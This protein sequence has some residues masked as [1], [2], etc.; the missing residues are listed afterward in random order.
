MKMNLQKLVRKKHNKLYFAGGTP[1]EKKLLTLIHKANTFEIKLMHATLKKDGV[2]YDTLWNEQVEWRQ[3]AHD[4]ARKLDIGLKESVHHG[5]PFIH[6]PDCLR[7]RLV[8]PV[9]GV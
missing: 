6:L 1:N 5:A 9:S 7:D 8:V 2:L 3:K 4:L